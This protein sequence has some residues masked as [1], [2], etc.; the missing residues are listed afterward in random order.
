MPSHMLKQY[1]SGETDSMGGGMF[2]PECLGPE[3]LKYLN[4]KYCVTLLTEDPESENL[5]PEL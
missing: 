4:F 5:D 1:Q 2:S 3:M